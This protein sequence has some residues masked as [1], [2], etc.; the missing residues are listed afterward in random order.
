MTVIEYSIPLFFLL[1]GAELVY[2]QARGTRLLRL[3]DS[4]SNISLGTLSQLSALLFKIFTIG[5]YAW[6]ADRLAIQRFVPAV[7]AWI[8]GAPFHAVAAFPWI[9]VRLPEL[10][11]WAAVF[12][13][14]DLAYYWS[15]RMSHEV[16]LLWAGHVVHHSSEEYNLAVAL[17]QSSLHGLMTWVF[18]VP[19]ALVGVPVTMFVVCYGLNL[20]YQFWIHTR[21]VGRLNS[22][23][24]FV[25]N[26]PSH[27]RVHHGVNPKYQ[28]R[29]YAGVLIVW[30]RVFGTFTAEEEEPV[31]GITHPLA[32]WNPLWANV[33]VFVDIWRVARSTR[34]WRNKLNAVFGPPSWRPA[35]VG[36]QLIPDQSPIDNFRKFDPRVPGSWTLYAFAQFVFTVAAGI[37]VLVIAS[38][39][40]VPQ[41]A[42]LVFYLALSLTNVGG[43][44]EGERWSILL[45]LARLLSLSA[46]GATLL[47]TSNV[48]RVPI[49]LAL[50]WFLISALWL[51]RVAAQTNP[52][53]P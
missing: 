1:I 28:D 46:A 8:G 35:D 2:A 16:H 21:A 37:G 47:L 31:Y 15:H 40:T 41:A 51:R 23:T 48:S 18:Y 39:L 49:V 34:G 26:T 10:I 44:L 42:A 38:A 30:D 4:I 5:I 43:L 13:L 3:N 14:V 29:N 45:E 11:S 22:L 7:P 36:P 20:V 6:V 27:H 9:G 24:E 33:H 19:L 32:S 25:L 50:M 17:R 53:P 52:T 12:V